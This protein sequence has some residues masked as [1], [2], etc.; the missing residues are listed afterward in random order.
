MKPSSSQGHER[1]DGGRHRSG[2]HRRQTTAPLNC[3]CHRQHGQRRIDSQRNRRLSIPGLFA[4]RCALAGTRRAAP[5]IA[6][7]RIRNDV[8]HG[9]SMRR[10]AQGANPS[11]GLAR[12][13]RPGPHGFL[14]NQGDLHARHAEG[15]RA[16]GSSY[17]NRSAGHCLANSYVLEPRARSRSNSS[18]SGFWA[19]SGSVTSGAPLEGGAMPRKRCHASEGGA[20]PPR[21]APCLRGR[22]PASEGCAPSGRLRLQVLRYASIAAPS[23]RSS[24]SSA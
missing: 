21:A 7:R 18:R 8:R 12:V 13:S 1:E 19:K 2:S 6:P 3:R 5:L 20:M 23:G 14:S 22:R 17:S 24:R 9:G 15:T 4:G 10:R 11:G 16:L